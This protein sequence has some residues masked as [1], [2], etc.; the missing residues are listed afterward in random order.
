MIDPGQP[1]LFDD[2]PGNIDPATGKCV[3]GMTPPAPGQ[4]TPRN[5]QAVP[6]ATG[7]DLWAFDWSIGRGVVAVDPDGHKWGPE[8][9][10]AALLRELPRGIVLVG[11]STFD[12]YDVDLRQQDMDLAA[13][14][15]ITLRTV[16][17]RGNTRRRAALGLAEKTSQSKRTDFEDAQ[18]IQW[19]AIN[20]AHLKTP[21]IADE[22]WTELRENAEQRFVRLRRS[23]KKDQYARELL[24]RIEPFVL[25][26]YERK[27]ALGPAEGYSLVIVAAVGVAAEF[28]SSRPDFERLVG[29]YAHGYPSQFRS[30]LYH[31]G[32]NRQPVKRDRGLTLSVYRREIRWLYHCVKR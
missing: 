30:D 17:A 4:P 7:G 1:S 27:I 29:I 32:W 31:W 18:A 20:G 2:M 15:N 25:Q 26:P 24:R 19:A 22:A 3:P 9:T 5:G 16:P 28:V 21:A 13:S 11:E 14:R 6:R 8:H 23:G 12:S 10:L